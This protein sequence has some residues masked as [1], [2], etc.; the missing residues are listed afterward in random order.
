MAVTPT[1]TSPKSADSHSAKVNLKLDPDLVRLPD[2]RGKTS[3]EKKEVDAMVG[4]LSSGEVGFI[5]LDDKGTPTGT[6][7][8]DPPKEGEVVAAVMGTIRSTPDDLVTPS[9]APITRF[10]NPT[11][12]LWDE[13]LLKRNPV[14]PKKEMTVT[15]ETKVA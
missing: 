10:M 12:S 6:A 2:P 4:E 8:D 15:V 11:P 7:K 14:P 9:G 1:P 13:N 3:F 5:K